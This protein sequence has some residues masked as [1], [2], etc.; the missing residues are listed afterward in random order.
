MKRTFKKILAMLLAVITVC[1]T[2]LLSIPV[3]AATNVAQFGGVDYTTL[4]DAVDA[5]TATPGNHTITLLSGTIDENIIIHQTADVNITI[6]GNGVDTIFAGHVEIYGHCRY[7]Y[8]ETF[9]YL[10]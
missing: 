7:Q 3:F 2:G 9:L 10:H 1:S 5:A 4:Q 8:E 6:K